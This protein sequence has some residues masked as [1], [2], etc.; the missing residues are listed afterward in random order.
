MKVYEP[1]SIEEETSNEEPAGREVV[2]KWATYTCFWI[3]VLCAA[4]FYSLFHSMPDNN[5]GWSEVG[6]LIYGGFIV[7]ASHQ[8]LRMRRILGGRYVPTEGCLNTEMTLIGGVGGFCGFVIFVGWIAIPKFGDLIRSGN[9]GATRGNLGAIRSALSI[10]Y[11]DMEGYYPV[12]PMSITVNGK[13]IS[14]VP[15]A[16]T[17]NYHDDSDEIRTG[18]IF[19]DKGGFL[20]N[21]DP[22]DANN[23]TL[24]VNCTHTDAR[25]RVWT[26]Y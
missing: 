22:H 1:D 9:E 7:F 11:G 8:V 6:L 24:W 3:A 4:G 14:K 16:K 21:S 15:R 13:Y 5:S 17:P 10:Y 25:G 2:S 18:R 12:D 26:T 23:G 20:Y 19:T